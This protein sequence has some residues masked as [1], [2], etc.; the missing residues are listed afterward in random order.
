MPAPTLESPWLK[1]TKILTQALV[2]SGTLNIGLIATFAYFVLK[3]K[4]ETLSLELKPLAQDKNGAITTNAEL[5]RSYCLLPYPELIS[6][7]EDKTGIEAG[8]THRDLALGCLVAFHHFHLEKALGGIL[9]QKRLLFFSHSGAGETLQIPVF[10]GLSDSQFLAVSQYAKTEKWPFT[11]QGLFYELK[12]SA[13]HPDPSL[14]STFYLTTEYHAAYLLLIRSGLKLG[15]E[16]IA[17]LITDGAWEQLSE[18]SAEQKDNLDLSPER[19]F[20]FILGYLEQ[21]S[22]KAAQLLAAHDLVQITKRCNDAQVLTF[23]D[24]YTEQTPVFERFV[25]DLLIAPRTEAVYRKAA[26]ILYQWAGEGTPEPY[27]HI[28]TLKRFLPQAIAQESPPDPSPLHPVHT[29]QTKASIPSKRTH[30]VESGDNLWKIA[31]KYKVSVEELMRI[32]RLDS[33]KLR[34]GKQLEIPENKAR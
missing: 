22:C 30:T 3:E 19:R 31:R 8:L 33:E 12:R 20:A 23:L 21:R 14:L 5:L 13:E 6:R 16:E 17:A 26:S 1:K 15:Q 11:N 18:L 10:P 32:N 27:D 25:K 2:L 34:P 28:T 4:Q 9:L 24:L 7:L 29:F